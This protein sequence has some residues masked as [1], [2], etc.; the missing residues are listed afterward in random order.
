MPPPNV[1][2]MTILDPAVLDLF[3][4]AFASGRRPTATEWRGSLD[5]ALKG[6]TRCKNDLKHS[7]LPAAGRC[8]WCELISVSR[9]MFFLPSQGATTTPF[10]PE[11]IQRLIDHL[12]GMR[13]TFGTYTRPKASTPSQVILPAGLRYVPHP[14]LSPQ[15]APPAPVP[16]PFL[17]APPPP[18]SPLPKP[19][20]RPLPRPPLFPDP[21]ALKP[22]PPIPIEAPRPRL[23]PDSLRPVYPLPPTPIPPD[24]FLSRVCLAGMIGGFCLAFVV[25]P[26]GFIAFASFGLWGLILLVTEGKRREIYLKSLRAGHEHDCARIYDEYERVCESIDEE[27]QRILHRWRALNAA[28]AAEHSRLC[29][30]VDEQNSPAVE[31][32]QALNAEIAKRYERACREVEQENRHILASWNE[33]NASREAAYRKAWREIETSNEHIIKAWEASK[34]AILAEHERACREVD[35]TNRRRIADWEAVNA[36]W[37]AERERW[38]K[39]VAVAE[40]EILR[41]EAGLSAN[42]TASLTRFGQR[43]DEANGIVATHGNARLDYEKEVSQA[44]VDSKNIQINAFL[45]GSLIRQAQLKGITGDRVL[46]MES[47]GIETAKDVAMLTHRKVPGIGPVLRGR[48]LQWREILILSFEPKKTLPESEKTRI[49]ARFAPVMLPLGQSIQRTIQD[50]EQMIGEHRARESVLVDDIGKAVQVAAVAT[51]HVNFF[52]SQ[53]AKIDNHYQVI[54]RP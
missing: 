30:V 39:R 18:P 31:S 2:P 13:L 10:R 33:E 46:A 24:P 7:F 23:K 37:F 16:M 5:A 14:S 36:P 20:I 53:Q 52:S 35:A 43:K 34:A 4:R 29:K 51:F 47:F 11:D 25:M 8:P 15:P 1:P 19:P 44:Y 50:L 21:P 17:A 32:W 41:L 49:A 12:A 3:E 45:E 26:V 28:K 48:L 27:N 6:L 42:R 40:A 54:H 9:V 38:S 22:Y